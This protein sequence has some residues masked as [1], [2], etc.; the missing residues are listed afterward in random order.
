MFCFLLIQSYYF[1]YWR[2]LSKDCPLIRAY[3]AMR[4]DA[5]T[6]I[7][8][9]WEGFGSFYFV[10]P[11]VNQLLTF[12]KLWWSTLL[13]NCYHGCFLYPK[14]ISRSTSQHLTGELLKIEWQVE[15]DELEGS[16][17]LATTIAWDDSV[18]MSWEKAVEGLL[19]TLRQVQIWMMTHTYLYKPS[20]T[21]IYLFIQIIAF[22]ICLIYS[23]LA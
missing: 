11:Q 12:A 9:E 21:F 22:T 7:S 4:F 8:S 18:L 3:G 2:F 1:F 16:S 20:V 14:L 17:M 15:F 13:F 5:R 10:V 6:A 19:A 23:L